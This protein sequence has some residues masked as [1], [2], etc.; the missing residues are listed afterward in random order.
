MGAA[1]QISIERAVAQ[2]LA[3]MG[4]TLHAVVGQHDQHPIVSVPVE[5]S[6]RGGGCLA[7]QLG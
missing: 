1:D 4:G 7:G 2:I 3:R 6:E 5:L